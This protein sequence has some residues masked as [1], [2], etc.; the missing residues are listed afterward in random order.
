MQV[1]M[2]SCGQPFFSPSEDA[3]GTFGS[4]ECLSSVAEPPNFADRGLMQSVLPASLH[5]SGLTDFPSNSPTD[6]TAHFVILQGLL[7]HSC[8]LLGCQTAFQV[9]VFGCARAG[10]RQVKS[11]RDYWRVGTAK[12]RGLARCSQRGQAPLCGNKLS[13]MDSPDSGFF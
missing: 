3:L 12:L 8:Q 2:L 4:P 13:P 1:R 7:R 6:Q 11:H 10:I 9:G 5:A